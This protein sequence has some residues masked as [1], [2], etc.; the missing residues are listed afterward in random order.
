[1]SSNIFDPRE[2]NK[3]PNVKFISKSGDEKL[4]EVRHCFHLYIFITDNIF[5]TGDL[6]SENFEDRNWTLFFLLFLV[7]GTVHGTKQACNQC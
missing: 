6:D 7:T 2:Q 5:V 1:M 4:P 3:G